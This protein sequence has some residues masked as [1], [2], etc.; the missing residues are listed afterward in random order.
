VEAERVGSGAERSK[1]S[2]KGQQV[3]KVDRSRVIEGFV[4]ERQC[5]VLNA[6]IDWEPVK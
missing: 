6:L 2:V 5:L 3:G 1:W 4:A